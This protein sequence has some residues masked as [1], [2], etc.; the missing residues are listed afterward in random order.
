MKRQSHSA[1]MIVCSLALLI[2]GTTDGTAA[3]VAP[4][5]VL[6][7]SIAIEVGEI[8]EADLLVPAFKQRRRQSRAF[9]H[10]SRGHSKRNETGAKNDVEERMQEAHMPT[11]KR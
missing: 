8:C 10:L 7:S 9:S 5:T 4:S 11:D 6:L 3:V 2:L 1:A